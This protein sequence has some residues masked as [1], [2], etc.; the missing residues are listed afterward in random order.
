ML[1]TFKKILGK[2]ILSQIKFKIN[3][4]IEEMLEKAL[5]LDENYIKHEI[6]AE[7]IGALN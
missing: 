2:S 7:R 6:K 4:T 1:D 3:T 5:Q